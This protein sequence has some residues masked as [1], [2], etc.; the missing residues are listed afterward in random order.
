MMQSAVEGG[1]RASRPGERIIAALGWLL[2]F[3][4]V[5]AA[6]WVSSLH[7]TLQWRAVSIGM[8]VTAFGLLRWALTRT[9]VSVGDIVRV[10]LVFA[11]FTL[12]VDPVLPIWSI[13]LDL[14]GVFTFSRVGA[15]L[16]LFIC[17]CVE[18]G[19]L[20][21]RQRGLNVREVLALVLAPCL[22]NWL[23]LLV[24]PSL[25][26]QALQL[27]QTALSAGMADLALR[28]LVVLA[29]NL[30]VVQLLASV[31]RQTFGLHPPLV[32]VLLGV[33]VLA[34]LAPTIADLPWHFRAQLSSP[35]LHVVTVVLTSVLA[36]AALWAQTYL[37]TGFL[38]DAL[39]GRA[40]TLDRA[41][42]HLQQGA[43]RG[44][45]YGG[46]FMILVHL[47]AGGYHSLAALILAYPFVS[48]ALL[49]ALLFPLAKTIVESF[50]G[51]A[52]FVTR[53]LN[54]LRDPLNYVRGVVIGGGIVLAL[55]Q[56]LPGH[57]PWQRSG[58]GFALGALA[59]AGVHLARDWVRIAR[60]QRQFLQGWKV[61]GV[62]LLLGGVV[63]AALTWYGESTQLQVILEKFARYATL[64]VANPEPYIVYPLFS[65]W[66]ALNLGLETGGAR[67]L[68][69]ESLSG[70]IG[71]S[72]AA[73]LFSVNLVFLTALLQR[74]TRPI[75]EFTTTT[76]LKKVI[77]EA[78]RVE[79]WG[80][81]MAPIIYSFLRMAPDPAWYNQ[82]G[83][84]RTVVATGMSLA[85]DDTGF[86]SWSLNL[87]M[88]LLAYDWLRI[89]I[90]FDHMGL[91]VA[92]LVNLSFIGGDMLDE[93]TARAVGYPSATR[94]IPEGLRRFGTWMP[95]LL[96]F[97]IP[98][99]QE[100][101]TAWNTAEQMALQAQAEAVSASTWLCAGFACAGILVAA[102]RLRKSGGSHQRY[103]GW[104]NQIF[105]LGNERYALELDE[106]GRGFSQAQRSA[107]NREQVDLT[108]R[109]L[110][111]LSATGKIFYLLE[112]STGNSADIWSLHSSPRP[113]DGAHYAVHPLPR[114]ALGY[115]CLH[116]ELLTHAKVSVHKSDALE[117]W[118][119]TLTNTS[120]T[121]RTVQLI[122]FRDLVLRAGGAAERH[123]SFND[124]HISTAFVP[125]LQALFASNRL[126][127]GSNK[128][129][130][131][132]TWFHAVAPLPANARLLGFQDTRSGILG[133][134][135]KR[136]PA[137]LFHR[138]PLLLEAGTLHQFDPCGSLG[139]EVRL[140]PGARVTLTFVEG[141]AA[142]ST[143]AMNL[144]YRHLKTPLLSTTQLAQSLATPRQHRPELPC[145]GTGSGN[146][147]SPWQFSADG[148]TLHVGS[149]TPRPWSHPLANALG[150][151][152][153][154]N[155]EGAV[156]S[157]CGNS[158][159]NAITPF[160]LGP[161]SASLPGQSWY[162][163]DLDR[164]EP[165][166]RLPLRLEGGADQRGDEELQTEFN[167]G[168]V[169]YR[170]RRN[171]FSLEMDLFTLPSQPAEGRL[172]TLRNNG[173]TPLRLRVS[174]CLQLVLAEIQSDTR[175][176]LNAHWDE[177]RQA[178]F[179]E[180]PAQQFRR[181]PVFV[182]ASFQP[183]TVET[184]YGRFIGEG[185][186]VEIPQM[187]RTGKADTRSMDIGYRVAALTSVVVIPPGQSLQLGLVL[188][189][190]NSE[191]LASD[192]I[193]KLRSTDALQTALQRTH[194]WWQDFL[195]GLR[196]KTADAAFDRLVND[197]LPYQLVAARLWGRTGPF[198]R[199]GAF[200][201]R[202]QL[203]DVIPLAA[204]HP[205]LCRQQILLHAAQQFL[206]GD[207]LQWWHTTW[208]GHT[209]IGARNKAS[210]IPLWL[211]YVAL[212]YVK[213]SGDDDIWKE[214]LHFIEGKPIPPQAEGIVFVP[215]RSREKATLYAHCK[216]AIDRVLARLG[217]NGLPLMGTGDWND[218]LDA[219]GHDGIGES[220]WLGF[221]LYSVLL[222][223]APLA[224]AQEGNE[225]SERLRHCAAQLK[226]ALDQQWREQRYVRAITDAG[227]ELIFDDALMSS[228][229]ILSGAVDS[230]HGEKAL[231]HGLS[232]L[233]RD[234]IVL[235]LT[236]AFDA[237]SKP[238]PGRIAQYPPGVREN[239]A[240]YSHGSSWLVD[241]ALHLAEQL[242]QQGNASAA[243][244]W[245][246]RAGTVWHKISPL[247]HT[248]PER[249]LNYGLEPHQQ[250]AD[251]YFGPG[252]EGRGGWSWYT[253]SA[254][255]MLTAARGLL[256][257]EFRAG[258]LHIAPW[259]QKGEVW[260]H[261]QQ[262]EWRG[263]IYRMEN[264]KAVEVTAVPADT[265]GSGPAASG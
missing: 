258:Q 24:A 179:A 223:F 141:W 127:G 218:G 233:E 116:R 32:L 94:Y 62:E 238:R 84:I 232:A 113:A 222:D 181:G 185:G 99:G 216:L 188:G 246:T 50:D 256:G 14:S 96:P 170:A 205:A 136:Y 21:V 264:G 8:G 145:P 161:G 129:P 211:P 168:S 78:L 139:V 217:Q 150:Y 177:K 64:S 261:L 157:F 28:L 3:W 9:L 251:V 165:L 187:A 93:K 65:K 229:P 257:L 95:L 26:G 7:D 210:D 122:S 11:F 126:L 44:A 72:M 176:T 149:N 87:F 245:R 227:E 134:G 128:Q 131:G 160:K 155:N 31:T 142:S 121:E 42:N 17:F 85:L 37:V 54:S 263:H 158:Q 115:T 90:W 259:A 228:W 111:T 183:E 154:A 61:Y 57:G 235:L 166:L 123:Q 97:Y 152:A 55:D 231:G 74:N 98:R 201:F 70:V 66:G 199:S 109:P 23:L 169:K 178:F 125:D 190:A 135:S 193:N 20:V 114:K 244:H 144:L 59:Y 195:G 1:M 89:L 203:Q 25:P 49:G 207:V 133:A 18:A 237:Q 248:A 172:L 138:E 77:A 243:Q 22:F 224:A 68:F 180:N 13:P 209:G 140:S 4:L 182:A 80:L 35:L 69:N 206:E 167:P 15:T 215:L 162:F 27:L 265:N 204:T 16:L 226:Q 242:E 76:G 198:Q 213:V 40:P 250:A 221:F 91:R 156:Y 174:A 82:D 214:T 58:F 171:H 163:W 234:A 71:W 48:G 5:A 12:R 230:A 191:Q 51:S 105:K 239:G 38:M 202:D 81:W 112:N 192:I 143:D 56:Q 124:L 220:V 130:A 253:G 241:A 63:G 101:D 88:S 34:T 119:I 53:L 75:R 100:W 19:S 159:Q 30:I 236:P 39:E 102:L 212:H 247:T 110:S 46:L 104:A 240:Q 173:T 189:Q 120:Q 194:A 186:T 52:P 106:Q 151:G 225:A 252:Y 208:D 33:S 47:L 262:V 67:L 43:Y 254:A 200:G 29:F 196:V 117:C 260:P 184:L 103:S 147:C 148:R 219:V 41:Q 164:D 107:G 45:V 108:Q 79:R 137:T 132:E 249:W 10:A 118:E 92:T 197:W 2:A 6:V 175:G 36:Q 255:R 60:G 86:R 146:A 73:P 83:A 153:F